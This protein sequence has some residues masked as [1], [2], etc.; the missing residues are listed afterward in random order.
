MFEVRIGDVMVSVLAFSAGD[1]GFDMARSC[2]T[3]D[4]KIG[5]YPGRS[6]EFIWLRSVSVA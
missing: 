4:Y 6:N 3:K 2:Q 5:I 1:H